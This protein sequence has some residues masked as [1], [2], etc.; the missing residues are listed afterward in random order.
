M[1]AFPYATAVHTLP[2]APF[3]F[4]PVLF[5]EHMAVVPCAG[6]PVAEHVA[7][8]P[9]ATTPELHASCWGVL[10][11]GAPKVEQLAVAL[12]AVV[13]HVAVVLPPCPIVAL[14]TAPPLVFPLL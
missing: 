11:C 4:D 1:T 12:P 6:A 2:R 8:L 7:V 13:E 5:T 14:Q 9:A 3:A 10:P